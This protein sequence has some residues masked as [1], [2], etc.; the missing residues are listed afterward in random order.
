MTLPDASCSRVPA[1]R[2]NP[3]PRM[4]DAKNLKWLKPYA[5]LGY[6]FVRNGHL[7][8]YSPEGR[9]VVSISVT[10]HDSEYRIA[11]AKLRRHERTRKAAS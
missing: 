6:T 1:T 5:A 8:V 11:K 2:R 4:S 10:G 7:N 9:F 3:V